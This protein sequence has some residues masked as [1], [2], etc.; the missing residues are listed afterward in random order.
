MTVNYNTVELMIS[1][2]A[3]KKH[4]VSRS[5]WCADDG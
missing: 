3:L 2:L 4:N 5:D 1:I